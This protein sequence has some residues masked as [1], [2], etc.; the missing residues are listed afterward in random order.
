MATDTDQLDTKIVFDIS[1]ELSGTET[2]TL[3]ASMQSQVRYWLEEKHGTDFTSADVVDELN[4]W[5][6]SYLDIPYMNGSDSWDFDW[7]LHGMP[8]REQE[9]FLHALFKDTPY[10]PPEIPGQSQFF[11]HSPSPK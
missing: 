2:V 11:E 5:A 3:D 4:E 7:S 10:I 1:Y 9:E 8:K 6:E